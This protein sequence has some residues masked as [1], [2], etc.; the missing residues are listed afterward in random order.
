MYLV[1][2]MRR[3]TTPRADIEGPDT[4]AA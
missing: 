1:I 4:A 2:R 3:C